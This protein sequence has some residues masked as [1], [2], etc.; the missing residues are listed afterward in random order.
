MVASIKKISIDKPKTILVIATREIGDV[1][2]ST[3][4]IHSLKLAWPD[5]QIDVLAFNKKTGMLEGNPDIHQIIEIAEHPNIRQ[6]FTL[7]KKI[8]R[9]YELAISTLAGDKPAIYSFLAASKRLG[10]VPEYSAKSWLKYK[11]YQAWVVHDDKNTHTVR[12]NLRLI[13]A[14]N[15]TASTQ[16]SPPYQALSLTQILKKLNNTAKV[17]E[18]YILHPFPRWKYKRWTEQ[19]WKSLIEY[20]ISSNNGSII[21]TGGSASK[22]KDFCEKLS[23]MHPD[24]IINSAGKLSLAEIT[25]LLK[26]A[27]AYIG[28]DTA[29]THQAAA[30]GIP[31]VVLF[32]PSNPVKWG[33]WPISCNAI[34]SPYERFRKTAQ[35]VNNVA[36]IQ[37]N[38]IKQCVPCGL[39]G[40]D[41]NRESNSQCLQSITAE[42]VI[43]ALQELM[44]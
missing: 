10:V 11:V 25:T 36:L 33:P 6:H 24:K 3:P 35:I 41:K 16:I 30:C 15:I 4:I 40:C 23:Q 13:E 20:I 37:Y 8:F 19:G 5:S 21:L 38:H 9:Q 17:S 32:G 31:T 27:K 43:K 22:E 29:V 18:Y 7:A 39:E 14:I 34:S 12:Q 1:L 44:N 2:L 26:N 28:P 42:T